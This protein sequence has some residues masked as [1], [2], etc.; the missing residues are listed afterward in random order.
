MNWKK[1]ALFLVLALA[2]FTMDGLLKAYVH[3]NLPL[4]NASSP[5]Y[6]FGGIEVFYDWH[7]V[8]FSLVHVMNKGAA[9][10]IFASLQE[11]LLYGRI[12]IIGGLLAYLSFVKTSVFRKFC[13]IL[14]ATGALG[15]VVDYF[16]Y[17]HVV[18]MFYFVFWGY[19]YPVFNI[20]DSS[21]F[22]GIILLLGES[23]IAKLRSS[24]PK[25]PS[26]KS[27]KA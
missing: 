1:A 10:G 20:A 8:D 15:N 21:I 25:V 22:A 9:W 17:G 14:I 6:P 27:A 24:G 19:S 5:V 16:I 2:I 4:I 26:R 3:N 11:Y 7:G 12:A 18:D 13:L 23:F